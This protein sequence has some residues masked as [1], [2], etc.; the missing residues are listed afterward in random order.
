MGRIFD[1]I[2]Q[3]VA[4]DLAQAA[5]ITEHT[6]LCGPTHH[7]G[8]CRV[9]L[10]HHPSTLP[11]ELGQIH[12]PLNVLQPACLNFGDVEQVSVQSFHF[13]DLH[14]HFRQNGDIIVETLH[15]QAPV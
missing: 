10:V 8:V 6:G 12:A 14:L 4:E 1:C 7:D 5:C 9:H 13:L 3:Q 15:G 2:A 11:E